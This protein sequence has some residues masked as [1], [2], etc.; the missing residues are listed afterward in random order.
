MGNKLNKSR[1]EILI[2]DITGWFSDELDHFLS[3]LVLGGPT[4]RFTFCFNLCPPKSNYYSVNKQTCDDTEKGR[5]GKYF[6][7]AKWPL[8]KRSESHKILIEFYWATISGTWWR[9]KWAGRGCACLCCPFISLIYLC[10]LCYVVLVIR[11]IRALPSWHVQVM[12]QA[13]AV[14]DPGSKP[15]D[16]LLSIH[17]AFFSFVVCLFD[18]FAFGILVFSFSFLWSAV[19]PRPFA[20]LEGVWWFSSRSGIGNGNNPEQSKCS[21]L[22]SV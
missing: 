11:L 13:T 7:T 17:A 15:L 18:I 20:I 4:S 21:K 5:H 9:W 10:S 2:T 22:I 14:M 6:C 19:F 8:M 1:N 3:H 12:L 16:F